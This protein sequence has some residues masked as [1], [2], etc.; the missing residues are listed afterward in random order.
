MQVWDL[1]NEPDNPNR[2]SY[3]VEGSKTEMPEKLKEEMATVLLRKLFA[4]AREVDPSQPLT[5][6]VWRGDWSKHESMTEYNR[7]M[8]EES[9]VISYHCYDPKD[10]MKKRI[11]WLRRYDRPVLCTEYMARGNNSYFDPILG[12]LKDEKVAAYNWGFVDGKSQTIYP[13]DTW[14]KKYTGRP[15]LWFHDIFFGDGKV[16]R[17]SEVDYI[18][19]MTGK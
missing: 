2:N 3:G 8:V 12:L 17:Q 6:G 18:K 15:D 1:F 16:Y 5:A 11:D 4:W 13:W 10:D 19:K 9:D 7:V 14:Q